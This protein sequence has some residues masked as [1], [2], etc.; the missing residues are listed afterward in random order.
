MPS[1]RVPGPRPRKALGQHFLRDTGVLLDIANAVRCP[2]G[3]SILE[4]G[5]GTGQLTEHLLR[6]HHPVVALEVE[7]RLIGHLQ[8]RFR[9]APHLRIVPGDARTIAIEDLMPGTAP[10]AAV[11]NLPYFAANPIIRH[12]LESPR[13]PSE[14]IAMVQ[15]EVARELA[16]P[17]GDWSLLTISVQMYATTELLFDVPP[18][19]FDPPPAVVS[20]VVRMTL[21]PQPEVPAGD[22]PAFFE[23]VSKV[24]RNPRKQIHNG[25]SRGVWL[26]PDGAR[27][28][29]HLAGIEPSRRP[30]TLVIPEWVRLMETC[31]EVRAR[32]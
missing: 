6:L 13:K 3:G 25:L 32:G 7:E 15:R 22:I 20:S 11:G 24:F 21:R 26:P 16:A 14:F 29:L 5:A 31:E 27:E 8:R 30:E 4:I 18:E 17:P 23:F 10:F 12:V 2:E 19:A 1:S 9:N 28:A